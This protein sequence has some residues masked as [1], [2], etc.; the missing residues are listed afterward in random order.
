MSTAVSLTPTSYLVLG[1]VAGLG[2][3]TPYELKQMVATSIGYFWSFPHSQLYAEPERLAAAGL[4]EVEQEPAGRRRKTY[5]ITPAGREAL[6]AWLRDP[7]PE[8]GEI[9]DPGL[10]KLFFGGLSGPDEVAAFARAQADAF[11]ASLEQLEAIEDRITGHAELA[12]PLATL[13]LGMR[14]TRAYLEFWED[15]AARPPGRVQGQADTRPRRT[16]STSKRSADHARSR[17]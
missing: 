17:R 15:V 10:L 3:A 16:S 6:G 13:R 14:V 4:L 9:R 7:T 1:L 2:R 12:Y 11:R 8:P 5:S